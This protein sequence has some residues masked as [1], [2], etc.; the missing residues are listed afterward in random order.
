MK[1]FSRKNKKSIENG[2]K[3]ELQGITTNSTKTPSPHGEKTRTSIIKGFRKRFQSTRSSSTHEPKEHIYA[4]ASSPADEKMSPASTPNN[5]PEIGRID[6]ILYHMPRPRALATPEENHDYSRVYGDEDVST[7]PSPDPLERDVHSDLPQEA[8]NL[9]ANVASDEKSTETEPDVTHNSNS[10]ESN[11]VMNG[12]VH[13]QHNSSH[14]VRND[15]SKHPLM[16]EF[17]K[18]AKKG[19]YWGPLGREQAENKLRDLPEASFLVRDSSDDRYLLSL[20]FRSNSRTL[21]T[22]IEHSGINFSFYEDSPSQSYTSVIELI[23]NS[24]RDSNEQGVFCYSRSRHPNAQTF[25]VRLIHPVSRFTEVRPL[26]DLCRFVI[27][28]STRIDHIQ[29]LPVPKQI[30]GYLNQSYF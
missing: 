12:G 18:L 28:Q 30:K 8:T 20:S 26:Q 25:P 11:S 23:E 3:D 7:T 16:D 5:H 14:G 17:H 15:L 1:R 13:S 2:M 4:S 22:R 29:N 10:N 27:R 9:T 24:V 19:W 21:H 6:G